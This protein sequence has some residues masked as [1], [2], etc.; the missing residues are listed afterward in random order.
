MYDLARPPSIDVEAYS[1][2]QSI[3]IRIRKGFFKP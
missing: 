1:S 2:S 3:R